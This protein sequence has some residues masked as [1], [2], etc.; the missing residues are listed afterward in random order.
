MLA[1]LQW[2]DEDITVNHL[3]GLYAVFSQAWMSSSL[4]LVGF[5]VLATSFRTVVHC[6]VRHISTHRCH[7]FP[8]EGGG[9]YIQWKLN[10][11][12][13]ASSTPLFTSPHPSVYVFMCDREKFCRIWSH[14]HLHDEVRAEWADRFNFCSWSWDTATEIMPLV[15]SLAVICRRLKLTL[16]KEIIKKT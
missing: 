15:I 8:P 1:L 9:W 10:G 3:V 4:S 2:S 6:V 12:L 14:L 5:N 11:T 13:A 7:H 16:Q